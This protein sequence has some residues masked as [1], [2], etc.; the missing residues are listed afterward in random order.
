MCVGGGLCITAILVLSIVSIIVVGGVSALF[1]MWFFQL[2]GKF[3]KKK[4]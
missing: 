3:M 1:S 4:E 2:L